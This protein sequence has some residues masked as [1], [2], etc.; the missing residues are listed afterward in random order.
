MIS[1][2]VMNK[3]NRRLMRVMR[4]QR[5]V[6]GSHEEGDDGAEADDRSIG[7]ADGD[8]RITAD[9]TVEAVQRRTRDSVLDSLPPPGLLSQ[10]SPKH[11]DLLYALAYPQREH[12]TSLRMDAA[13]ALDSVRSSSS[14]PHPDGAHHHHPAALNDEELHEA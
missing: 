8:V 5:A 11:L 7:S 13:A 2:K 9:H 10:S 1:M 6:D 4:G 14:N 3:W 12:K